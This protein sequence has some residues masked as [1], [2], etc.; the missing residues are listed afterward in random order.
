MVLTRLTYPR[1][2]GI[3]MGARLMTLSSPV[4]MSSKSFAVS[5][6]FSNIISTRKPNFLAVSGC[7][8]QGLAW[9]RRPMGGMKRK[10]VGQPL[11]V[12]GKG[13][14]PATVRDK[15]EDKAWGKT[16]G[17]SCPL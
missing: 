12:E 4:P 13:A 2:W 5:K 17:T 10:E 8:A 6:P 7:W 16:E 14:S 1:G 9:K 11:P 3:A 15:W